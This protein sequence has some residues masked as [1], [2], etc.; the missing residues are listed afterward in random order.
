MDSRTKLIHCEEA[1]DFLDQL[2]DPITRNLVNMAYV[3]AVQKCCL[4]KSDFPQGEFDMLYFVKVLKDFF[5][6]HQVLERT[7]AGEKVG[8]WFDDPAL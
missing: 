6:E 8:A 2:S 5:S 4:E 3:L 1:Q 7:L